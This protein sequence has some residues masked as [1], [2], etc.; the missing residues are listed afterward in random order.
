MKTLIYIHG[1]RSDRNSRKFLALKK[2]LAKTH[3]CF[4]LEWI[5]HSDIPYLLQKTFDRCKDLE[6]LVLIGD[7][8]GANLAFQLREMRNKLNDRLV[9]LSPLLDVNKVLS[10]IKF[11]TPF[12]SSLMKITNINNSL[13][14]ASRND[15]VVN[16][17]HLF[18]NHQKNFTLFEVDDNHRLDNFEKYLELISGYINEIQ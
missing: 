5:T 4:C 13:V 7:S 2:Y 18:A 3:N 15:E 1:Y 8:T 16:Q 14:V 12:L 11:P 10:P 6:D 17:N 9:L